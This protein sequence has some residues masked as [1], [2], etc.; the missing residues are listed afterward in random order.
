[1]DLVLSET[2]MNMDSENTIVNLTTPV[3][4]PKPIQC[5]HS[6]ETSFTLEYNDV[7]VES[8]PETIFP[9]T[10]V[11]A[12]GSSDRITIVAK[13]QDAIGKYIFTLSAKDKEQSNLKSA[14]FLLH[15]E[16]KCLATKFY[17]KERIVSDVVYNIDPSLKS[18]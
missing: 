16:I 12:N 18:N 7:K 9:R 2:V 17:L 4:S 1:M 6:V 8:I 15:V 13:G 10:G 14:D 3:F 5:R 11:L